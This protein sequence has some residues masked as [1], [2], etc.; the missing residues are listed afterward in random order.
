MKPPISDPF[1]AP[2]SGNNPEQWRIFRVQFWRYFVMTLAGALS[3]SLPLVWLLIANERAEDQRGAFMGGIGAGAV[4]TMLMSVIVFLLVPVKINRQKLKSTNF[5]G[6]GREIEWSQIAEVRF[7]WVLL[8]FAVI[9]TPQ[10]RN[11]IWIP[12][13]LRDMKGF[14]RA[15][16]ELA[17]ADNQLRLFLQKRKF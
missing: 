7:R 6:A 2:R 1:E 8:P 16:E 17:P 9:S 4:A 13:F 5:W 12:L 15:V 14:A 10:K 3:W 11:F